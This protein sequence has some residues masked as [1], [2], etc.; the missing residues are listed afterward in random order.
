[1]T[2]STSTTPTT[3]PNK[4]RTMLSLKDQISKA[5]ETEN[6][7]KK[8]AAAANAQKEAKS[9]VSLCVFSYL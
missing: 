8:A 6:I 5:K 1:M 7:L 9:D 3:T 2:S 4:V